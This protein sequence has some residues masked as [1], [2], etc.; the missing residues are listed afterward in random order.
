MNLLQ[1]LGPWPKR[2]PIRPPM[3]LIGFG[4]MLAGLAIALG[5]PKLPP[6]TPS[7]LSTEI[8]DR[9]FVPMLDTQADQSSDNPN[10]SAA[11]PAVRAVQ[12]QTPLQITNSPS[13]GLVDLSLKNALQGENLQANVGN[14]LPTSKLEG[15]VPSYIT[16]PSIRLG[17]PVVLARAETVQLN[18]QTFRQWS[19]PDWLAAGWD[20][21]SA[22]LGTGGNTVLV[23]HH[24]EYGEVFRHL[25]SLTVGDKIVVWSG[26][27]PFE[28]RVALKLVLPERN[29]SLSR[30][31][32]NATWIE[33]TQ[34]ERLT[35]VTCWPYVTNTHRLI[36]V[37]QPDLDPSTSFHSLN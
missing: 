25:V 35:L 31:L 10:S 8:Q 4:L 29:Q 28:Y 19:A 12:P 33:P 16:I 2:I 21:G 30:R 6:S 23:G 9:G 26:N 37:A 27:R 18:G 7:P 32:D 14:S 15:L 22:A 36:I 20:A 11:Q 34:D 24:N 5:A 17:A 13:L 3:R 1:T